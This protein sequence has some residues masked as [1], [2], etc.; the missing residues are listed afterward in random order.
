V[1]ANRTL[2]APTPDEAPSR[3]GRLA[4]SMEHIRKGEQISRSEAS[5]GMRLQL[6]E[7]AGKSLPTLYHWRPRR[8]HRNI[9]QY[10]KTQQLFGE[11]SCK[12]GKLSWNSAIFGTCDMAGNVKEWCWNP[13]DMR[14]FILGGG[15][16]EPEYL[17]GEFDARRPFDRSE[18]FGFR[19]VKYIAAP[20]DALKASVPQPSYRDPGKDKPADDETFRVYLGLHFYDKT[21]LKACGGIIDA[22]SSQYWSKEKVT[23]L[24]AYGSDRVIA[25]LY[26]PKKYRISLPD[27]DLSRNRHC[28]DSES[29]SP[30]RI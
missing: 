10:F 24:A 2:P 17:F 25:D 23:F 30:A 20:P 14:R 28:P 29:A 27:D 19:C 9:F 7:F 3:V 1:R 13:V 6:C 18:T 15:W 22:T 26:F 16:N 21:D 8:Q 12:S 5:A 11:R 4:G